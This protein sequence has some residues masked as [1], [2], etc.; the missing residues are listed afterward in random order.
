MKVFVRERLALD[1]WCVK[2]ASEAI[3]DFRNTLTPNKCRKY[4]EK[5][6]E[7]FKLK[8]KYKININ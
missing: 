3:Q 8:L 2:V 5:I 1:R 4:I 7:V 6:H